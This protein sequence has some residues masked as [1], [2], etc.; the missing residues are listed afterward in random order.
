MDTPHNAEKRL[1]DEVAELRQKVS[2]LQDALRDQGQHYRIVADFTY[3]WEYWIDAR[4]ELV[5]MSPSCERVTG[6][7]CQA[8]LEDSGLLE[9]IIHPDDCGLA[10][11][12]LHEDIT[13]YE[14]APRSLDFRIVHKDGGIR[15]IGHVC[16]AVRGDHG[17]WMGRRC[18]NRD[19]TDSKKTEGERERLIE[20]LQQALAQVKALSGFLPICASC[21]KIRDDQGYW[22][23]LESYIRD[24]SEAEFSHG[25][26]PDCARR[27]Y[28]DLYQGEG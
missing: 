13:S 28:P 21:K 17:E 7:S 26:C 24:H 1:I 23:Q 19:I 14:T 22:Q 25:L 18:S 3:D 15:W 5:Y 6:Y 20:Q 12:H 11:V 8:F 27:L 10:S 16:Q 2:S 9:R 4:G